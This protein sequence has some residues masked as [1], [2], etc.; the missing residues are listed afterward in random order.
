MTDA[1]R[2]LTSRTYGEIRLAI[3]NCELM[4]GSHVKINDLCTKL[5]V[6]L[7]A[8]REALSRLTSDGLV[9]SEPQKGFIVAPVS[10]S[11]L[12]DLT[13]TR[14]SIEQLCLRSAIENGNVEWEAAIVAAHHRLTRASALGEGLEAKPSEEW[15][16]VHIVFHEA[17]VAACTSRRLLE[18]RALYALQADRYMRIA[19][20]PCFSSVDIANEHAQLV[21]AVMDRQA[22]TAC[23]IIDCHI[24]R[25]RD[26]LTAAL[27]HSDIFSADSTPAPA[28]RDLTIAR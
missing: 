19:I 25:T 16:K 22:Q 9:I 18:L 28:G 10:F 20:G 17:L 7:S 12:D 1:P 23:D 24:S 13:R 26:V 6:S 11:D 14:I 15:L 8:V 2:S 21:K 27:R 4:P 5:G 3:L